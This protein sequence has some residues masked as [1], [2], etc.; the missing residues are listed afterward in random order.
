MTFVV[1]E[2]PNDGGPVT[3]NTALVQEIQASTGV[4]PR[5]RSRG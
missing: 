2:R 5:M 3:I 1:F 4:A